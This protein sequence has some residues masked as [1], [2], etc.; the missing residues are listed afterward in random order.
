MEAGGTPIL[1]PANL[2][3]QHWQ[4]LRTH[5][6]GILLS[7]GADIDPARFHGVPHPRVYDIDPERDELEISLVHSA[8]EN[9]WPLL[10]ICRGLQVMNVALGGTLYTDI[11]DQLSNTIRHDCALGFPRDYPA[12][13]IKIESGSRLMEIIG[14]PEIRVNSLHHQGAKQLASTFKVTALSPDGLVEGI[15]IPDH[16]FALAVQWHPEEMQASAA[17]RRLF[18]A[19]VDA[20]RDGSS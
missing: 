13:T 6:N 10:G 11:A 18:R 19:F 4:D 9:N 12:H 1:I 15:E 2:S 5:L 20:A 8:V 16:Q 17:M 3:Q 7:G 14:D